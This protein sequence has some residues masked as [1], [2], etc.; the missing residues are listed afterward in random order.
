MAK[1][2]QCFIAIL[3][4]VMLC[5]VIAPVTAAQEPSGE[6]SLLG[7]PPIPKDV[8]AVTGEQPFID[9]LYRETMARGGQALYQLSALGMARDAIADEMLYYGFNVSPRGHYQVAEPLPRQADDSAQ[10]AEE[11]TA[12]YEARLQSYLSNLIDVRIKEPKSPEELAALDAEIRQEVEKYLAE[13]RLKVAAEMRDN[14]KPLTLVG[15][16]TGS[17]GQTREIYVYR[18]MHRLSVDLKLYDFSADVTELEEILQ[19]IKDAPTLDEA[20]A[21]TNHYYVT[22]QQ[23]QA[24]AAATSAKMQADVSAAF[25]R[26]AQQFQTQF[27]ADLNARGEALGKKAMLG[28]VEQATAEAIAA[29][30]EILSRLTASIREQISKQYG[31]SNKKFTESEI[32]KLMQMGFEMGMEQ[33]AAEAKQVFTEMQA[34]YGQL[35]DTERENVTNQMNEEAAEAEQWARNELTRIGNMFA[36]IPAS[37]RQYLDNHYGQEN[38]KWAQ[39]AARQQRVIAAKVLDYRMQ[40]ADGI[41]ESYRAEI[42]DAYDG[43]HIDVNTDQLLERLRGDRSRLIDDF[44]TAEDDPTAISQLEE[45]YRASWQAIRETLEMAMYRDTKQVLDELD[46]KTPWENVR[47]RANYA[48]RAGE[49][50]AEQDEMWARFESN[51]NPRWRDSFRCFVTQALPVR[52]G[53]FEPVRDVGLRYAAQGKVMLTIAD[54]YDAMRKNPEDYTVMDAL[55]L[56]D[57]FIYEWTDVFCGLDREFSV[58]NYRFNQIMMQIIRQCRAEAK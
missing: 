56:K 48:L 38:D 30:K 10:S 37:T 4:A 2:K 9:L 32:A 41:L 29:K 39:E 6:T 11:T 54:R 34:K 43:G 19:S 51:P 5:A 57:E 35:A 16:A 24:N 28:L 17:D 36:G 8:L 50:V 44:A 55:A 49:M 33:G 21:R 3:L 58:A 18:N 46:K 53:E 23:M 42:D 25:N 47:L 40:A 26:W 45:N 52:D 13:Y 14:P 22:S 15:D 12:L 31:G 1:T 20:W 7:A 27:T